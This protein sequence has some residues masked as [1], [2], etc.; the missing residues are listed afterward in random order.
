MT[1][2]Y[3]LLFPQ[4]IDWN[5]FLSIRPDVPFSDKVRVPKHSFGRIDERP[6]V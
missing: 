3:N 6:E 2:S 4:S 1:D 5:R